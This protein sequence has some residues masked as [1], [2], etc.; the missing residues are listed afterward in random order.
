MVGG[1][2]TSIVLEVPTSASVRGI[3]TVR[4]S[5]VAQAEVE[6]LQGEKGSD[7]EAFRSMVPDRMAAFMGGTRKTRSDDHGRFRFADVPQGR[8]RVRVRR[9]GGALPHEVLVDIFEG[10]NQVEIEL[11]SARIEGRVVDSRGDA[12]QGA[13]V[14]ALHSGSTGGDRD[15][16]AAAAAI[17]GTRPKGGGSTDYGGD[18]TIE[19]VPRDVP[20]VVEA[21]ASG[22]VTNQSE[23]VTVK[24]G[25]VER[26]VRV[27]LTQAGSIRVEFQNEVGFFQMVTATYQ[28]DV[29]PEP[30]LKM[31]VARGK[32][33]ILRD[34]APGEWRVTVAGRESDD[35]DVLEVREGEESVLS[36]SR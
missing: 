20:L 24:E 32:E 25:D 10:E 19:D 17:F 4:G 27:V 6:F 1:A 21:S 31:A 9:S 5:V 8:H 3:V 18:F 23:E 36:W 14:R 35:G 7:G 16:M 15:A 11:P 28:G 29:E 22:Y 12:I 26:G 2:T 30:G 34:L 33:A 13:S